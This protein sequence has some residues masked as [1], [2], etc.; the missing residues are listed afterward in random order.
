MGG[1]P[2][3]ARSCP[4]DASRT[5]ARTAGSR[6]PATTPLRPSGSPMFIAVLD[7]APPQRTGRRHWPSSTASATRSAPCRATSTSGSTRLAR[8]RRPSPSSTNGSTS[9]R[10]RLPLVRRVRALGRG[11][12]TGADSPP[13]SRRFRADWSRRS[14]PQSGQGGWWEGVCD[15][16][17]VRV[18]R[19]L[20]D[21]PDR[22]ICASTATTCSAPPPV[23]CGWRRRATPGCCRR[24]APR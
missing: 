8:T 18:R 21:G 6:G 7:S 13:V 12:A 24:H 4:T 22:P 3:G 16:Q 23:P 1:C 20:R 10:S 2:V 15:P 5:A 14:D 9:R 17:G 11:A 19:G